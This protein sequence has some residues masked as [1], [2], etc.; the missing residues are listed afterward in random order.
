MIQKIKRAYSG[1]SFTFRL[2]FILLVISNVFIIAFQFVTYRKLKTDEIRNSYV[3]LQEDM[4]LVQEYI[5]RYAGNIKSLLYSV[6]SMEH[7]FTVEPK[8]AGRILGRMED[9]NVSL[10]KALYIIND[11]GDILTGD[12]YLLEIAGESP[13]TKIMKGHEFLPDVFQ[14]IEPYDSAIS[15]RTV[16][17]IWP[18]EGNRMVA[19]ELDLSMVENGISRILGRPYM[20]YAVLSKENQTVFFQ[21]QNHLIT[22]SK[23]RYPVDIDKDDLGAVTE[24]DL[25][26]SGGRLP[27]DIRFKITD[28]SN[29]F[30]WNVHIVFDR[31]LLVHRVGEIFISSYM[32]TWIFLALLL[33]GLLISV[34]CYTKPIRLLERHMRTVREED[35][36]VEIPVYRR[37]EIGRLCSSYN[38][39]IRNM[40]TMVVDLRESEQNKKEYELK[41]LRSQIGPHFLYNTLSCI[42][43]LARQKR[44]D[45][46]RESIGRLTRLLAFSFDKQGECVTVKQ[47][48]QG[49]DNYIY[50]QKMRY[51]EVF[52]VAYQVEERCLDA[53]VLK[54]L[55]QPLVENCIFHGLLPADAGRKMKIKIKIRMSQG[56]LKIWIMDN[57]IGIEK[58]RYESILNG[59]TYKKIND[60]FS[61]VG[62]SNVH[63]RLKL[64]FGDGYGVRIASKPGMGTIMCLTMPFQMMQ[65]E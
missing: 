23:G 6:G 12:Q 54:L 33:I 27:D 49:I 24:L 2:L 22:E 64:H 5:D 47:E 20:T 60:R 35:D 16:A 1:I 17:V 37:D 4:I 31:E 65:Q 28:T 19:A 10:V 34:Y 36:L 8:E 26:V 29:Y 53:C 30:S 44:V 59:T 52:S 45:E 57:G 62:L 9:Y 3:K 25:A 48:M 61:N 55:L 7:L 56:C 21:R 51:G 15:N 42:S 11:S 41:M 32:N 13:L 39:L 18:M 50:I 63:Q 43:S 58:E 46:V 14:C 40:K 38:N